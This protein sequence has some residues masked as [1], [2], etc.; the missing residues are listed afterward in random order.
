MTAFGNVWFF[1]LC[2]SQKHKIFDGNTAR[3]ASWIEGPECVGIPEYLPAPSAVMTAGV[4]RSDFSEVAAGSSKLLGIITSGTGTC[5]NQR[6]SWQRYPRHH[7]LH[8]TLPLPVVY[9]SYIFQPKQ[10]HF[11]TLEVNAL[12]SNFRSM[13]WQCCILLYFSFFFK[14]KLEGFCSPEMIAKQRWNS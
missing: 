13:L 4:S 1:F 8:H 9:P 10:G 6:G 7:G 3:S 12:L 11:V 2:A 14:N 5:E